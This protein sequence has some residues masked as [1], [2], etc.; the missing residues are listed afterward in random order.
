MAIRPS[1]E[2]RQTQRLA[3]TPELRQAIG[4]LQMSALELHAFLAAEVERNPLLSLEPE[5]DAPV[6]THEAEPSAAAVDRAIDG[7]DFTAREAALESGAENLY[8]AAPPPP[9]TA[10][11]SGAAP[12]GDPGE[13]GAPPVSLAAHLRA[14]LP[15]ARL[16]PAE[17]AAAQA[18]CADLDEDGYLRA[19]LDE[20]A[21]R[22][23]A[24]R[25]TVDRALAAIRGCDPTGVGACDLAD[26]LGL[27]L[28]ERGRL[29]APMRALLANLALLPETP[30]DAMA[31]LC[32]LSPEALSAH[33]VELRRL[34]PRP[35]LRIGCEGGAAPAAPDILARPDGAGGWRVELNPEATPRLLVDS[36]YAARIGPRCD[37]ARLYLAE[38]AQTA[39]WLRRSLDQRAR[40]ILAVSAEIVRRQ[41]GF[42]EKG[43]R[44]LRPMT[45]RDVAEAVGV[46][47]STVSRVSANKT[48]LTPRGLF[49]LRAFFSTALGGGE[50]AASAD[51]VR[52]RIRA[53][54]AAETAGKPLS[55]DKI[56]K[57]LRADGVDVARRT[58]AKYRE[59][60]GI[61]SSVARR[62]RAG[63]AVALC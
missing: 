1:L 9:P 16:S 19:D 49:E 17:A 36:D 7:P 37:K 12:E 20:T 43:V 56:V 2:L 48:I 23:G 22:L 59:A 46:H 41:P 47:E 52:D 40:T 5:S 18:L 58:V 50:D 38:C 15:L 8:E 51:A 25:A 53:L 42:L 28:A 14:Q 21:E 3:M 30:R 63:A 55:D 54:V 60:L 32:G 35:G 34:D 57:L 26:C 33:L 62:R 10:A 61:P 13:L 11:S 39:G 4:M 27:Q 45:L 24:D 31:A 6:Q 44:A 29:D